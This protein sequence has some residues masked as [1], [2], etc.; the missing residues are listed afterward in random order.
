M[1]GN[2][3]KKIPNIRLRS[4]I[5]GFLFCVR[6]LEDFKRQN[7]GSVNRLAFLQLK[8]ISRQYQYLLLLTNLIEKRRLVPLSMKVPNYMKQFISRPAA[9]RH[10]MHVILGAV[11]FLSENHYHTRLYFLECRETFQFLVSFLYFWLE[12]FLVSTLI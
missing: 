10:V 1:V 8:R 3:V 12:R 6:A 11:V 2:L 7:R 4:M 9:S 5:L